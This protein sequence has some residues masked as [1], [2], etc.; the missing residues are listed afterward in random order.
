MLCGRASRCRRWEP[1]QPPSLGAAQ[2]CR[3]WQR[4]M[5]PAQDAA[6][7]GRG[8]EWT[9][10]GLGLLPALVG[11]IVRWASLKREGLKTYISHRPAPFGFLKIK[12]RLNL[13]RK[14]LFTWPYTTAG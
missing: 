13:L 2:L 4:G 10:R 5:R 11:A 12:K 1:G 9:Q 8:Q 6:G 14:Q 3:G 7:S